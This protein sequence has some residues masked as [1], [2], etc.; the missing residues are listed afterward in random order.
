[1]GVRGVSCCGGLANFVSNCFSLVFRMC[2]ANCKRVIGAEV[3]QQS[4]I[5]GHFR[6]AIPGGFNSMKSLLAKYC[7]LEV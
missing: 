1:M 5:A 6:F 7:V 4:S 3:D 2:T